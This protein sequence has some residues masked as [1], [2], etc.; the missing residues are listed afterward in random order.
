MKKFKEYISETME[1]RF[2]GN[3]IPKQLLDD[4]PKL[5]RSAV[6]GFD[7][8]DK[9]IVISFDKKLSPKSI[10]EIEKSLGGDYGQNGYENSGKY[11]MYHFKDYSEDY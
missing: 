4:L 3:K 10:A 1:P 5:W 2:T 11:H 6:N 8:S 7:H 9:G